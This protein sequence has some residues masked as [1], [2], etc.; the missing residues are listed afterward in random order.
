MVVD[1]YAILW[2]IEK[3]LSLESMRHDGYFTAIDIRSEKARCLG[4]EGTRGLTNYGMYASASIFLSFEVSLI[5]SL[6]F[7]VVHRTNS[8]RW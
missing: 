2:A 6:L 8:P 4:V 3:T 5:L 1:I 7:Y